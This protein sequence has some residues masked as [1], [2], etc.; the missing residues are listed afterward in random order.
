MK[1]VIIFIALTFVLSIGGV[2][3]LSSCSAQQAAQQAAVGASTSA[4]QTIDSI[5]LQFTPVI[6]SVEA[7]ITADPKNY[8]LLVAQARNYYGWGE[9]VQQACFG[10]DCVLGGESLHQ[11]LDGRTV[12]PRRRCRRQ[13]WLVRPAGR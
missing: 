4:T 2:A 1:G 5:S 12:E 13:G 9:Q 10:F 8:G 11:G 3:G 7:S 6:K